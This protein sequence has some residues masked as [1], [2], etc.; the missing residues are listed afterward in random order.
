VVGKTAGL[1]LALT[2]LLALGF[3][4]AGRVQGGV[5]AG[6]FGLLATALQTA[7]VAVMPRAIEGAPGPL[8]RRHGI[9]MALR[10]AGVLAIPAAVLADR[11][12]FPPLPA[13]F[14]FVG[15]LVPLLFLQARLFR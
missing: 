3:G 11:E 7:A 4:V 9:G 14:G 10:L 12:R 1:G 2:A 15:V 13:A 5:A 8:F 6:A